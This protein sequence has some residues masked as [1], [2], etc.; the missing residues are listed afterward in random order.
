MIEEQAQV[1]SVDKDQAIIEIFHQS[2]C[3][4]CSQQGSCGTSSLSQ[5]F[6]KRPTQFDIQVPQNT[7]KQGDVIVIGLN[8]LAYLKASMLIYFLPLLSLFIAALIADSFNAT[9]VSVT[10]AAIAGL[11]AG[12]KWAQWVAQRAQGQLFPQFV[13]K[14][15]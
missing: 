9:D 7:L 11:L 3:G 4:S 10:V 14:L 2:A 6:G 1:L 5:L 12:F 8:D 15:S 13:R